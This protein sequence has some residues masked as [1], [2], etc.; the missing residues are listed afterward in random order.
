MP[1]LADKGAKTQSMIVETADTFVRC[2]AGRFTAAPD[3][4]H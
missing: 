1:K 3:D 4:P 2:V